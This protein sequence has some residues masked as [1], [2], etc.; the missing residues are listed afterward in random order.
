MTLDYFWTKTFGED[1]YGRHALDDCG[2]PGD[3]A[4]LMV[5]GCVFHGTR[6]RYSYVPR[7]AAEPSDRLGDMVKAITIA[8]LGGQ[9]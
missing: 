2:A 7:H 6:L 8:E 3:V 9:P 4:H 5:G 1:T